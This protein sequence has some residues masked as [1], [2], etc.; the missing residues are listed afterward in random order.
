[1]LPLSPRI[2]PCMS[3]FFCQKTEVFISNF[4]F[5]CRAKFS[6]FGRFMHFRQKVVGIRAHIKAKKIIMEKFQRR[7]QRSSRYT[8][9]T[10]CSSLIL[11]KLRFLSEFNYSRFVSEI[12]VLRRDTVMA[13][14]VCDL[15]LSHSWLYWGS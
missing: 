14:P 7:S 8:V 15:V 3:Q 12:L 1:M 4:Q 2:Y 13:F 11:R 5:T 10:I 9:H 6:A